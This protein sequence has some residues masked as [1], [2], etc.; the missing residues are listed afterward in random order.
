MGD[1]G[2]EVLP[3]PGIRKRAVLRAGLARGRY[4]VGRARPRTAG[5][6]QETEAALGFTLCLRERH[7]KHLDS[8]PSPP[9][10]TRTALQ[11]TKRTSVMLVTGTFRVCKNSS[12]RPAARSARDPEPAGVC[13]LARH[14]SFP[15]P[16]QSRWLFVDPRPW[17]PGDRTRTPWSCVVYHS[18]EKGVVVPASR[19]ARIPVVGRIINCPCCN[20][21]SQ[22]GTLSHVYPSNDFGHDWPCVPQVH[23]TL[24]RCQHETCACL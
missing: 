19:R 23:S 2:R 9:S 15:F 22:T 10:S 5:C 3:S 17:D 18:N 21:Q 6:H 14:V 24:S 16:Q 1:G 12:P 8:R 11:D 13:D 4:P 7:K 20:V